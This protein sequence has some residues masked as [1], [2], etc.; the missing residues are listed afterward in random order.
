MT[1]R[2]K[3]RRFSKWLN[4]LFKGDCPQAS[5]RRPIWVEPLEARQLMAVDGFLGLLGSYDPNQPIQPDLLGAAAAPL[6][7]GESSAEGE[8]AADLVAFAKALRDSGT[9]FY[10][11]A[12]CP[13]CT[14]QKQLFED[15]YKYLPFIEVTNPDRYAQ[16]DCPRREYYQL[17]HLGIPR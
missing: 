12:W 15:G 7:E 6:G 16:S 9:K 13:F 11:A 4:E 10:G 8:A 3:R 5:A 2:Q 1:R 14:D 17:P